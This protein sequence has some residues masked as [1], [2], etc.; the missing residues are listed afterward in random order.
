MLVLGRARA[1]VFMYACA[2]VDKVSGSSEPSGGACGIW[3]RDTLRRRS[4]VHIAR[5]RQSLRST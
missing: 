3:A 1:R 2:C 4:T 5:P